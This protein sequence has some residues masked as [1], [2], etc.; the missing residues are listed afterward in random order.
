MNVLSRYNVVSMYCDG[1]ASGGMAGCGAVIREYY[2]E[3]VC[4]VPTD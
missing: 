3:G 4:A 1:C 2:E